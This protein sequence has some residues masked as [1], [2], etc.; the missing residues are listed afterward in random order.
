MGDERL[1]SE[2]GQITRAR[3]AAG[4]GGSARLG[5]LSEPRGGD[6]GDPA[7]PGRDQQ[8]TEPQD[9]GSGKS[10]HLVNA[11]AFVAA[12]KHHGAGVRVHQ[13]GLLQRLLPVDA[14][15]PVSSSLRGPGACGG[16]G[17][18]THKKASC[19]TGRNEEPRRLTREGSQLF[20][21]VRRSLSLVPSLGV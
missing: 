6:N 7:P 8:V 9:T 4:G 2:V 15:G 16:Q 20:S 10:M 21:W 12:E 3:R 18:G 1:R 13:R 14:A 5:R 17:R 19:R 11:S